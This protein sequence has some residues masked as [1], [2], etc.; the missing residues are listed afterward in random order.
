MKLKGIAIPAKI[1]TFAAPLAEN[2]FR[3]A[4]NDFRESVAPNRDWWV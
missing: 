4:Y 1:L 2:A 3:H